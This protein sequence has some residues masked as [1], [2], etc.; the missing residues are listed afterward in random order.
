MVTSVNCAGKC[1]CIIISYNTTVMFQAMGKKK[2]KVCWRDNKVYIS[3]FSESLYYLFIEDSVE[4][5]IRN[6]RHTYVF[7]ETKTEI[8]TLVRNFQLTTF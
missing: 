6:D 2:K 3:Y 1:L 7:F 8:H 5:C 4:F